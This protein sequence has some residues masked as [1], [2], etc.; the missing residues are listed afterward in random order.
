MVQNI[1]EFIIFNK[2]HKLNLPDLEKKVMDL[3]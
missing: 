3:I 2:K 1:R